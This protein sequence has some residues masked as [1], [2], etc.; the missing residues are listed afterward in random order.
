[1]ADFDLEAR[2]FTCPRCRT[3]LKLVGDAKHGDLLPE[4]HGLVDCQSA[5]QALFERLERERDEAVRLL[6]EFAEAD[7]IAHVSSSG[8]EN[9][10]AYYDRYHRFM[11]ERLRPF[12]T[13]HPRPR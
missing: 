6:H 3:K 4:A 13:A 1:M 11:S 7:D 2:T 12:L 8:D 9:Q 5:A 10:R